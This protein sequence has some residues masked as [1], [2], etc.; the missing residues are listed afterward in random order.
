MSSKERQVIFLL[1]GKSLDSEIEL[2][3]GETDIR[4]AL[5]RLANNWDSYSITN[6]TFGEIES[7]RIVLREL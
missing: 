7:L 1:K 5:E 3:S 2:D 6:S 4:K